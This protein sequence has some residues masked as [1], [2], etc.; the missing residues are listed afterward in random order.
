MLENGLNFIEM[1]SL[2]ALSLS[3]REKFPIFS[4]N[5]SVSSAVSVFTSVTRCRVNAYKRS[6]KN[7]VKIPRFLFL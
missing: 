3:K 7:Y 5:T 2:R 6:V 1:V 4:D